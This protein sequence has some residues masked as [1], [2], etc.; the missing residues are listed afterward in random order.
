M[1]A[2]QFKQRYN[3]SAA[4]M[5]VAC[6]VSMGVSSCTAKDSS[7]RPSS[8]STNARGQRVQTQQLQQTEVS[9]EATVDGH[10]NA[11]G[12]AVQPQKEDVSTDTRIVRTHPRG[13]AK[14]D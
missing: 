12:Q 10:R 3:P 2:K 8:H 7:T 6:I 4:I 9:P 5:L 11:R 1:I 13:Q 14:E